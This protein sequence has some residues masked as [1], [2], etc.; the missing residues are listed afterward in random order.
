MIVDQWT[1]CAWSVIHDSIRKNNT[2]TVLFSG[3]F[4]TIFKIMKAIKRNYF[5]IQPIVDYRD[6]WNLLRK[7]S[8]YTVQKEWK[9]L[10]N[11]IRACKI[12][13]SQYRRS[14]RYIVEGARIKNRCNREPASDDSSSKSVGIH[15]QKRYSSHTFIRWPTVTLY[16]NR[17]TFRL[18]QKWK[19][20]H[21][22]F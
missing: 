22:N 5:S 10:S 4:Y 15:E 9:Y 13:Y 20:N 21:C 12:I 16:L 2:K 14:C 19:A 1:M 18:Y 7:R 17:K 8:R 6:P 11:Y 3:P